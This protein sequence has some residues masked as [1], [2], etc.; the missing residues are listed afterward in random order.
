VTAHLHPTGWAEAADL[1]AADP[2]AVVLA[3]GTGLQPALTAA[4]VP[5]SALVHLDRIPGAR[6]VRE[7]DGALTVG[8]L[9]PVAE[10]ALRRWWGDDGPA[11][12]ATPAV[13]RRATLVGDLVSAFGPRELGPMA[14]ATGGTAEVWDA[15]GPRLVPVA[16]LLAD[17]AGRGVVAAV[18]LRAP[19]RAAHHRISVRARLSR[20][21]LGLYAARGPG[22][23]AAVS[24]GVGAPAL[25]VAGLGDGLERADGTAA[26]VD[27]VV[28]TASGAGAA[29]DA[30]ALLAGLARRVHRE[31]HSPPAGDVREVVA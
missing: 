20:V 14:V 26:L 24:V 1:L 4:A 21:E 2:R 31:L 11:W 10:P 9:V 23:G 6:T 8:A 29:P 27:A 18:T 25:P 12:F 7:A 22:C 19:D 16:E 5:P 15:R 17:G 13:R 30:V 3:G 28:G